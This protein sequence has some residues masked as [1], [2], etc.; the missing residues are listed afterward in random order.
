MI[1]EMTREVLTER[2]RE[3]AA[4]VLGTDPDELSDDSSPETVD[5]WTSLRHLSLV[6]AIEETFAVQ[7]ELQ[8]IHAAHRFGD[9]RRILE[10]HLGR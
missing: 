1:L 2:L 10:Q 6:A 8:E 9:L 5:S 3:V 4:T 7:F